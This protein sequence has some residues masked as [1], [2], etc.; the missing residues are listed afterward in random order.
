M[1]SSAEDSWEGDFDLQPSD[2]HLFRN[3][4]DRA[5]WHTTVAT[6]DVG[7]E[8]TD[9]IKLSNAAGSILKQLVQAAKSPAPSLSDM[10]GL[11]IGEDCDEAH[12]LLNTLRPHSASLSA[13]TSTSYTSMLG[14]STDVTEPDTPSSKGKGQK[15]SDYARSTSSSSARG[16]ALDDFS[17]NDDDDISSAFE[18]GPA[19]DKLCLRPSLPC[20]QTSF[21][22]VSE[23]RWEQQPANSPQALVTLSLLEDSDA[24][25]EHENILEGIDLQGS[26]F[27][28]KQPAKE[29]ASKLDAVLDKKRSGLAPSASQDEN[30]DADIAAGLV[31]TDDLDISPN[32]FS[33]GATTKRSAHAHRQ[34]SLPASSLATYAKASAADAGR[35]WKRSGMPSSSRNIGGDGQS[36]DSQLRRKQSLPVLN[37]SQAYPR[38]TSGSRLTSST[39]A[40]RARAAETQA[41]LLARMSARRGFAQSK[42]KPTQ[43][44]NLL[45][46]LTSP[47]PKILKRTS[48]YGDGRE[49]IGLDEET[50]SVHRAGISRRTG[51][52]ESSV[53]LPAPRRSGKSAH[54]KPGLIC[55]LG[56]GASQTRV[57]GMQ[58]NAKALRWDGNETVLRD[59]DQ[60]IQSSS[61]PALIS[62][63]T[64]G[65][66]HSASSSVPGYSSPEGSA[67]LPSIAS[68]VRVVGDMLFDPVQMR[69]IHKHGAEEE[70]DIFAELDDDIDEA[71]AAAGNT[72][73]ARK[74]K[75]AEV[76]RHKTWAS[77]PIIG[78]G[79]RDLAIRRAVARG[80]YPEGLNI[81]RPLYDACCEAAR[82][83]KI[84][85]SGFLPSEPSVIQRRAAPRARTADRMFELQQ[86]RPH[87]YYLST[88]ANSR[89]H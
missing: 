45:E 47:I 69:W 63:L 5:D 28:A 19:F 43:S 73:R 49:L 46:S 26:L 56:V 84:D 59:F 83:H 33:F 9:T 44:E 70:V 87:L 6:D 18:I 15:M 72:I 3:D 12:D 52:N 48:Q 24:D 20:S 31:I 89:P 30:A 35:L 41:T 17:E 88:L 62:Q 86:P 38:A 11:L 80:A 67:R 54:K 2:D 29:L 76:L 64:G 60:V 77:E 40:S 75:S 68:G 71:C 16:D 74:I 8:Q 34:V 4:A 81:D 37:A 79:D 25:D 1:A 61:R 53:S 23:D 55:P 21:D 13:S 57:R 14:L 42:L 82:R 51:S 7:D 85:V 10:E 78:A 39:A 22:S 36:Q 66:I 32:R 27:D 58:W 50:R 65:S